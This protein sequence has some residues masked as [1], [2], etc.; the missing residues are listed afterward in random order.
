MTKTNP[1]PT[2]KITNLERETATGKV[3][4]VHYTVGLSDGT[5]NAGAYGSIDV[6]GE[7]AVPFKDLT[8]EIIVRWVLEALG[9]E[10][11]Q[12][13]AKALEAQLENQRAPKVASGL[14]WAAA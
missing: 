13:V 10:K 2:W 4:T 3:T 7:L 11:V 9:D 8:E 5:Y 14:P 12:E 6:D 1:T